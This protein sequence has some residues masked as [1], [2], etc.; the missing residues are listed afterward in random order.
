MATKEGFYLGPAGQIVEVTWSDGPGRMMG[1][2]VYS[3]DGTSYYGLRHE[4][5]VLL[6]G[7]IYLGET[8]EFD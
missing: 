3:V 4:I 7:F 6:G 8:E 2:P 5:E 1:G